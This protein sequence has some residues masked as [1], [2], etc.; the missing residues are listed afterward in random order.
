MLFACSADYYYQIY[1]IIN[2]Y[3]YSNND[4]NTMKMIPNARSYR[5][6]L[7]PHGARG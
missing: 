1:I 3:I 4:K 6:G 2:N 7:R 5:V